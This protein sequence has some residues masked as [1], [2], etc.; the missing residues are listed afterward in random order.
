M[1]IVLMP[2]VDSHLKYD[3]GPYASIETTELV[4]DLRYWD[5]VF[6]LFRSVTK[7]KFYDIMEDVLSY[8]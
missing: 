4:F 6:R 8:D 1:V 2:S 7:D 3:P 5:E